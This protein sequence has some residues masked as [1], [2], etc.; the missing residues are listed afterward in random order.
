MATSKPGLRLI[1][2]AV[3]NILRHL[4]AEETLYRGGTGNVC[5]LSRGPKKPAI[6]LGTS[7]KVDVDVHEAYCHSKLIP[8]VRRYTGG[9]TVYID[10]NTL[11][12]SLVVDG[13]SAIN[14]F[15]PW[16]REIMSWTEGLFTPLFGTDFS[17]QGHDYTF[18]NKKFGGNAQALSR[19]R[20]VHHTSLL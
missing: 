3:D 5:I 20:F 4:H 15:K 11:L 14:G 18:G 17:L 9:G 7:G 12:L 2:G 13:A 8:I 10:S 16:P 1:K 19:G 6:V